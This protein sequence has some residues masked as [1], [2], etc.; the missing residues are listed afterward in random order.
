[1]S[2]T[3][4]P[5]DMTVEQWDAKYFEDFV[6]SDWFKK[7]TSS[8]QNAMIHVKEELVEKPGTK[9]HLTLVNEL[10]EQ[11]LGQNDLYSGNEKQVIIRDFPIEVN[12]YGLPL[13]FKKFEQKKHPLSLRMVNKGALQSWNKK[14]HRDKIIGAM[15]DFY[16]TNNVTVPMFARMIGGVMTAAASET[17]KDEWLGLNLD[18]VLFGAN[19]GNTSG[20]DHSASLA[21]IDST[22]DKL[23]TDAIDLMV[24]MA[25]NPSTG[26][27]KVRPIEPRKSVETSHG[28]VLFVP[29][30]CMRDLKKDPAFLQA[31]REARERGTDN[32][33]FKNANWIWGNVAIYEIAEFPILTGVGASSINVGVCKLMGAQAIGVAWGKRPW[34][35]TNDF[36]HEYQRFEGLAIM[37]YY[38][39]EKLRW[40]TGVSDKTSPT[41]HG[42]VT[43]YFAATPYA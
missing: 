39:V 41:D 3:E 22:N 8:D 34:T 42:M 43:G 12:E 26:K 21:N 15:T 31:N 29:T 13:K 2:S 5:A 9:V 30:L 23:T 28:Y 36:M 4:F 32:P 27:P 25:E 20:S 24:Y 38:E 40:G 37:Q 33:I 19:L 35:V 16:G 18:R 6:N 7:F 11:P 10:I 1:M 17:I 14:L